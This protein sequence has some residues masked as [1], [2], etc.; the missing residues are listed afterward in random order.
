VGRQE[1]FAP[2]FVDTAS[3]VLSPSFLTFQAISRT[4]DSRS[5]R[6]GDRTADWDPRTA[7]DA[8]NQFLR[9]LIRWS[10]LSVSY[11]LKVA[12]RV[13]KLS[14]ELQIGSQPPVKE[15]EQQGDKSN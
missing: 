4:K 9:L 5:R 14:D 15:K 11:L 7:G 8:A 1:T 12:N 10:W 3:T 2:F 13:E 6:G